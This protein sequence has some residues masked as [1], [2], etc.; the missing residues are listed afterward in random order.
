[1]LDRPFDALTLADIQALVTQRTPEGRR[2]EFKRDHYGRNDDARREF[3]ADVSALANSSGGDL[4]IGVAAETGAASEVCGVQSDNPDQLVLQISDA[5]RSAFEP[6]IEG[7]RVKWFPLEGGQG[8][9]LVRVPNS[10][11]GPHRVIVA[12]DSR[13]FVRDENGKHPMSVDEL[14]RA[15]LNADEIEQRMRKFR[16]ERLALIDADEGPLALVDDG[17]PKLVIHFIPLAAFADD[18]QIELTGSETGI[19]PLGASGWNSLHSIDGLVTYSGP[20]DKFQTV[21]AFTSLFRNGIVEA[22]DAVYTRETEGHR[23]LDLN[24]IEDDL[25]DAARR[26][27]QAYDRLGVGAPIYISLSLLRVRGLAAPLHRWGGGLPYPQRRDRVLLPEL[28][29]ERDAAGAWDMSGLRPLCDLL[30]NAF[31][32]AQSPNFTA[33]GQGRRN[34]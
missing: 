10:W 16:L 8:V 26:V 12:R 18:V 7:V 15:F 17:R 27:P 32:R 21:R 5:I 13:F 11:R 3:A 6:T 14:R 19:A 22:V 9:I 34:S 20:E 31:G 1:M 29:F 23:Q 28:R 24:G 2:I 30:W 4:L 33:D 25:L